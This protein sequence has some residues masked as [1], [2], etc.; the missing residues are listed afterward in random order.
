MYPRCCMFE[1]RREMKQ[2][3]RASVY[4]GLTGRRKSFPRKHSSQRIGMARKMRKSTKNPKLSAKRLAG[5]RDTSEVRKKKKKKAVSSQN[6]INKTPVQVPL[7]WHFFLLLI[8]YTPESQTSSTRHCY[9]ERGSCCGLACGR[10]RIR[11]SPSSGRRG[12]GGRRA[13]LWCGRRG[14]WFRAC[15]FR[16]G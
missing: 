10:R 13:G 11:A 4:I 6:I 15:P 9:P 14:C 7:A 16:G 8:S 12:G 1:L 3:K 5:E 2:S